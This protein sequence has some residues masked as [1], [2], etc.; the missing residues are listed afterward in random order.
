MNFYKLE[1]QPHH[2]QELVLALEDRE[3]EFLD[4]GMEKEALHTRQTIEQ[5]E[6]QLM[7]QGVQFHR[8]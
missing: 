3:G 2:L 7:R 6:E 4:R 1:L 5:I 8:E